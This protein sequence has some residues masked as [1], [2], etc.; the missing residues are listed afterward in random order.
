MIFVLPKWL[1]NPHGSNPSKENHESFTGI[2][3][4]CL[5]MFVATPFCDRKGR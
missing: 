2:L 3:F 4:L 5:L 1:V